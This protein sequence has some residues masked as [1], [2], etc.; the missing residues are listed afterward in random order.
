VAAQQPFKRPKQKGKSAF[1]DLPSKLSRMRDAQEAAP[2]LA[3][4]GLVALLHLIDDV[5]APLAPDQAIG[6]VA[7]AQRF[8]RIT[9]FH[10]RA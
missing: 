1:A 4:A 8:Q 5:N 6:P 10:G 9:N 2:T 3:L 7:I